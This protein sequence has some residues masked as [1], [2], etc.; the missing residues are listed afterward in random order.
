[1]SELYLG[2]S[3]P[4]I[5]NPF[6]HPSVVLS[7]GH[8]GPHLE[9]LSPRQDGFLSAEAT[10]SARATLRSLLLAKGADVNARDKDGKPQGRPPGRDPGAAQGTADPDAGS[11]AGEL[12]Q[13]GSIRA[14][15]AGTALQQVSQVW[16]ALRIEAC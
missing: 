14:A 16:T 2:C 6:P 1:V 13:R 5:L 8:Q 3:G 15:R 9:R 4:C 7:P 11:P 10:R 12:W